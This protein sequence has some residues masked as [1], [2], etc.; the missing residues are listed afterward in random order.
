MEKTKNHCDS[1]LH[2]PVPRL[3]S[4]YIKGGIGITTVSTYRA[5]HRIGSNVKQR[6]RL[7][8]SRSNLT[9]E[10]LDMTVNPVINRYS[11][12]Q[13]RKNYRVMPSSASYFGTHSTPFSTHLDTS[14]VTNAIATHIKIVESARGPPGH[15]RL[16]HPKHTSIGS[17]C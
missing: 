13:L 15:D 9:L 12:E 11:P 7:L 5:A 8:R 4:P 10:R 3:Q 14:K 2:A 6:L 16:P 17:S 1:T